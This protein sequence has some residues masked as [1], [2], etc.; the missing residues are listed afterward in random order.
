ME[1]QLHP[2]DIFL[3]YSNNDGTLLVIAVQKQGEKIVNSWKSYELLW[4]NVFKEISICYFKDCGLGKQNDYDDMM[5]VSF[6][7]LTSSSP[8]ESRK[9]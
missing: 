1:E 8:S 3:H 2:G 9:E 6:Q 5:M 4:V 7:S